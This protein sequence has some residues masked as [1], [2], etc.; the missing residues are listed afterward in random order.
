M[1]RY[2]IRRLLLVLPVI[3]GVA[4]LVFFLIH[5]I[6]GD[7]VEMMLGETAQASDKQALRHELR[8]DRPLVEQYGLFLSGLVRSDLGRS[9]HTQQTVAA[10]IAHRLPATLELALAAMLFA[11]AIALPLAL[12]AAVRHRSGW[13]YGALAAAL[14]GVSMP[15]FWLGPLLIMVFA[16]SLDWLPVSGREGFGSII[17]PA[18]T[19]GSGMAAILMRMIRASLLDAMQQEHVTVA[20]AK[21][22]SVW[23]VWLRY[24][25][26][27]AL[28]PVVTLVGLQFGA[29]LAGAII[30]ETIFAWPGLGRLTIQAIMSRDYPLVQGCVLVIAL[31]YVLV[32][33]ATDLLYAVVDPRIQYER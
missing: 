6:P 11:G 4:T 14:V 3:L 21:G 2:L 9:L 28:I 18:V 29:L 32:N 30:T 10:T 17:L 5:L 22:L 25:L 12:L 16:L 27:T 15:S 19:L 24:G 33:L 31:G 20:R 8:L 13:D 26:R 7:P 1:T 23:T